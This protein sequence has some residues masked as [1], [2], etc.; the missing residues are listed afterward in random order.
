MKEERKARIRFRCLNARV[1]GCVAA[2]ITV[3]FPSLFVASSVLLGRLFD[4]H[5]VDV[6]NHTTSGDGGVD[7]GVELLV[8][9]DG[10][11]EMAR[12]DTLDLEILRGVSSELKHL[13]GEVLEDSG[14]VDGGSRSNTTVGLDA[15]LQE[16]VDTT[17][18][19]LETSPRG[20]GGA[21]LSL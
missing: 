6:R 14:A 7:E 11:L 17:D 21:L 12:G 9:A 5:L 2:V 16:P 3:D 13:G 10:E 8:S 15:F 20:S 1:V 18:G 19:E 4:E